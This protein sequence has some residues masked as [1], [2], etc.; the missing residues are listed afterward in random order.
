MCD[1]KTAVVWQHGGG[2][3]IPKKVELARRIAE[4]VEGAV[5]RSQTMMF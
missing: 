1:G 5:V 3:E 4:L 2:H